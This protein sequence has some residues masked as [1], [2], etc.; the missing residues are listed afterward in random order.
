MHLIDS[1]HALTV[2]LNVL[3][4]ALVQA[5]QNA[6]VQ[7]R[8][9][10]DLEHLQE[11]LAH[12]VVTLDLQHFLRLLVVVEE[13]RLSIHGNKAI[14]DGFHDAGDPLVRLP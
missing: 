1:V 12:D 14:G 11:P 2:V 5:A 7:R 10:R 3:G 6:L 8:A 4:L 13:A 9:F